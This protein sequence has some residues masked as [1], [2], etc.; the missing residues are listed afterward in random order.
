MLA[1]IKRKQRMTPKATAIVSSAG[2]RTVRPGSVRRG[3]IRL[4]SVRP[5]LRLSKVSRLRYLATVL[6]LIPSSRLG[7]AFI[8]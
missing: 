6:T 1:I 4:G 3:S 7:A 5:V 8:A 2:F